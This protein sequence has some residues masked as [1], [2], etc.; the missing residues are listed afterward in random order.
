M[1]MT[2]DF[3]KLQPPDKNKHKSTI[4]IVQMQP[5]DFSDCRV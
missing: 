5:K 1:C 3:G 4:S 2:K